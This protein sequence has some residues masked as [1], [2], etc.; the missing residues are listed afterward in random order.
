MKRS[1]FCIW[2]LASLLVL[3]AFSQKQKAKKKAAPVVEMP[4]EISKFDEMLDATQKIIIIDSVIISKQDFLN[5]YKLSNEASTL[6]TYNHFFRTDSQPYA[7]VCV[8]QLGNKCW[9]SSE[10]RLY[11]ADK[12]ASQWSEPA[13]LEGLG[14]F[15]RTNYPFMLSD[16]TTLYF[17]A[18]SEEGLGGLDI[19]VSRY[20]SESGKFLLA[21]NIGLPFNSDANDYMYAVDELN[22]IGYFATDRKQPDGYVCIYTFIPNQKRLTYSND[23]LS[24]EEIRSRARIDR[25]ADTWNDGEKRKEALDRLSMMGSK[26][27]SKKL[28]FDFYVNDEMTYHSLAEF[29]DAD[30]LDRIN[31]LKL[32]RQRH[33]QLE[34]EME[35]AR[36]YFSTKAA[37]SEKSVLSTEI[38]DYEQEY[39]Q[40]EKDIR[41]LEKLIRNSEIKHLKP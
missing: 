11:T 41:Q 40:L 23:G 10:G 27:K 37:D 14:R 6:S 29:R 28:E 21:E 32:M 3:P 7:T 13:P 26:N 1:I 4:Q 34:R 8:N 33:Q 5:V 2:I 19:Y 15:Q 38:L 16:G 31:E 9:F 30:N 17:G 24:N 25:I 18:I 35:K 20:D 12:L 22:N 39:Y 36:I